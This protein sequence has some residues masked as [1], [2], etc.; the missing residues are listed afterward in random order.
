MNK[1]EYAKLHYLLAKVKY[2]LAEDLIRLSNKKLE[3]KY[4][5]IIQSIDEIEKLIFLDN[6]E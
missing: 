4:R 2:N 5:N 1:E 3:N 6:K